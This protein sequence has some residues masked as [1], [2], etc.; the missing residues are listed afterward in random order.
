MSQDDKCR[1]IDV[2]AVLLCQVLHLH[3][4]LGLQNLLRVRLHDAGPG[5]PVHRD[6]VRHHRVH[7]LPAQRRGLQMV[8]EMSTAEPLRGRPINFE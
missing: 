5:H 3:V 1:R 4:F 6:C 7:V 2:F 8:S